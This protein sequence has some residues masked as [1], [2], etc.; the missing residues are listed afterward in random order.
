MSFFNSKDVLG[1]LPLLENANQ[2]NT[3]SIK[4]LNEKNSISAS[5]VSVSLRYRSTII[6]AD[7][8]NI[9]GTPM[10]AIRFG[11]AILLGI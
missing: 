4:S 2:Y 8:E 9:N 10:S 5:S 11:M 3:K 7:R 6:A 1:Y